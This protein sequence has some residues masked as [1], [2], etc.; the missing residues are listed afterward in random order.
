MERLRATKAM[1]P[2][3]FWGDA[4]WIGGC[5][6]GRFYV[7]VNNEGWVEPCIFCHFATDNIADT[8]LAEAFNS[9]FFARSAPASPSTTTSTCRAC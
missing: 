8:S 1:F 6:A 7:H 2:V 3:D 5:N 4:P 9:P